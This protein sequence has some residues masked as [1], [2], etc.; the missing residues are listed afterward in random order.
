MDS[1]LNLSSELYA[2]AVRVKA[3]LTEYQT[4]WHELYE[5]FCKSHEE[6]FARGA[7][8]SRMLSCEEANALRLF[9]DSL[10]LK[11]QHLV[12]SNLKGLTAPV[13]LILN[14]RREP[15]IPRDLRVYLE[16]GAGTLAGMMFEILQDESVFPVIYRREHPDLGNWELGEEMLECICSQDLRGWEIC[17]PVKLKKLKT[18]QW[19]FPMVVLYPDCRSIITL[20]QDFGFRSNVQNISDEELYLLDDLVTEHMEQI[21]RDHPMDLIEMALDHTLIKNMYEFAKRVEAAR[22]YLQEHTN[23]ND[24]E[25]RDKLRADFINAGDNKAHHNDPVIL[26]FIKQLYVIE[27][28]EA[29]FDAGVKIMTA[30][31]ALDISSASHRD[32]YCNVLKILRRHSTQVKRKLKTGRGMKKGLLPCLPA[33]T[34]FFITKIMRILMQSNYEQLPAEQALPVLFVKLPDRMVVGTDPKELIEF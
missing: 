2:Q 4:L 29:M 9:K 15:V 33:Q 7:K 24:D 10:P 30:M 20:M 12:A 31:P 28:K 18:A 11:W 14:S 19:S 1:T 27:E 17:Y 16:Q 26:D 13:P 34:D 21:E 22:A 32:W 5:K 8:T 25:I 6:L 3:R 23:L